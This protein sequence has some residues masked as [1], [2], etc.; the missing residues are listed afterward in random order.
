MRL[1]L[2]LSIMTALILSGCSRQT[3]ALNNTDAELPALT[4]SV[5]SDVPASPPVSPDTYTPVPP[6]VDSNPQNVSYLRYS[7]AEGEGWR[8]EVAGQGMFRADNTLYKTNDDG[9]TWQRIAD[10]ASGGL[11][12]EAVSGMLFTSV[13]DGW[14]TVHS[15]RGGYSGLLRT[16]NGGAGWSLVQL[17]GTPAS[18]YSV[19]L[20]VFFS[21]TT[22]G[23]LLAKEIAGEEAVFWVT[24]DDGESWTAVADKPSGVWK[25]MNWTFTRE[26]GKTLREIRIGG[27]SWSY[28][29]V[30]W[31]R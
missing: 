31:S 11:P 20:P 24:S 19:E 18:L 25:E 3:V 21:G 15:P 4:A 8:M 10:T 26:E 6:S 7:L 2:V 14:I 5:T 29:G 30:Q 16:D 28:D 13:S 27:K 9:A 17:E 1:R 22:Y 12:S 23:L